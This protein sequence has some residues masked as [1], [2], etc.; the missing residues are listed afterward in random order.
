MWNG[1]PEGVGDIDHSP[2]SQLSGPIHRQAIP[3]EAHALRKSGVDLGMLDLVGHVDEPCA[4]GTDGVGLGDGAFDAQVG[5]MSPLA[6]HVKKEGL[7][8][9]ETGTS[10]VW[11]LG[12]I[13][14]P[15]QRERPVG[16]VLGLD[17]EAEDREVAMHES[18][19][20]DSQAVQLDWLARR[21]GM[22]V[23]ARDERVI[24]VLVF[25]KNVLV[26]PLKMGSRMWF[27]PEIDGGLLSDIEAAYLVETERVINVVVR[28]EDAIAAS[29]SRPQYLLAEIRR[30]VDQDDTL[31]A[32][33][34]NP[35]HRSGG[36]KPIVPRIVGC[37]GWAIACDRGNTC[38][39]T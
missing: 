12:D 31:L 15:S 10:L 34:I 16:T 20:L 6:E 32:L 17:T 39:C 36:P 22:C 4:A 26:H 30:S 18:Q 2:L 37:A 13:R 19:R 35:A 25:L 9:H 24:D 27:R 14:T 3:R 7:E 23:H 29:N 8:A 1:V 21:E 33:R 5:V 28:K 38:G 11:D